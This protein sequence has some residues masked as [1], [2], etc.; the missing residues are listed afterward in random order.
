MT[1]PTLAEAKS[2]WN[3][4]YEER[5]DAERELAA[6][7]VA[8]RLAASILLEAESREGGNRITEESKGCGRRNC[9]GGW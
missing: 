7:E 1:Q 9:G 4:A 3:E 8:L 5:L 2:A 6:K